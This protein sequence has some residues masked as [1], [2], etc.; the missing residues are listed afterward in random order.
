M[1]LITATPDLIDACDSLSKAPF[2]TVDTEFLR[3]T[4]F[5]PKLC[6][7]QMAGPAGAYVIDP[8]ASGI[9][10]GAFWGLMANQDIVKVFHA[11]RQDIEIIHH[12]TGGVPTPVF[13]SQIA[14][15]VCGFGEQISYMNLVKRITGNSLDK[16]SR[17]TDWARR[18]LSEKQLSYALGDVTHLR[19]IYLSL[20]KELAETGRTAWLEEEMAVLTARETYQLDPVDAWKRL[21]LKVK[22][23]KSLSILM[24][25]AEWRERLAQSQ[26]IPRSRILRDDALY[27]IANQAPVTSKELS[28]LRSVNGGFVRSARARPLLQ[29]V[30]DGLER[31]MA[32][33]PKLPQSKPMSAQ[34]LATL[35]L[36]KVLLKSA[37]ARHR[38]APR[39]IADSSDL[40]KL[41]RE[42]KPDIPAL[43]G[44][45]K[46]LFGDDA[47]K[48]K[49]G[50]LAL[51]LERGDVHVMA[52][53]AGE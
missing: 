5:W 15:M 37:A 11:A 1:K 45:R 27:D 2:V 43:K 31:D 48:L 38:V 29:A 17:F 21:K 35:E 46:E 23:R 14:A 18:P 19:D 6:L 22:N 8:L 9:D 10:L 42:D 44:W 50:E 32:L 13:D 40:E 25:V 36:L 30:K 39:M 34:A 33:T 20:K 26:N 28:E 3:E 24:S 41:A 53:N 7:I 4:T 49:R 12:E 52:I 47:L 16:S 51:K